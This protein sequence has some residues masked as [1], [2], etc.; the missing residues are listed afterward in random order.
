VRLGVPL[1]VYT[2]F[3]VDIG[4]GAFANPTVATAPR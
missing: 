2:V 1:P 3:S 4:G